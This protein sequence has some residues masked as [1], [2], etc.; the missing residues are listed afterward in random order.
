MHTPGPWYDTK[1]KIPL[2]GRHRHCR[3]IINPAKVIMRQKPSITL[4]VHFAVMSQCRIRGKWL[5]QS[6][7]GHDAQARPPAEHISEEEGG[8][9]PLLNNSLGEILKLEVANDTIILWENK[10]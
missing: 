5:N 9:P 4:Y 1:Y 8:S 2:Q 10:L 3:I 7:S 6:Q